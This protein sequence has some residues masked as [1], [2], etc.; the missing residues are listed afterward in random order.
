M[1]G[2]RLVVFDV[3]GTLIDSQNAIVA[4][5]Q[6]AFAA[7]GESAPSSQTILSIVGLSLPEAMDAIAPDLPAK[8]RAEL[9][10]SYKQSAI[11][12]S[13][14]SATSPLYPGAF[15]ALDE[16]AANPEVRL[17]IATGKARRGLDHSLDVHSLHHYFVTTQTADNHPSKPNPSMLRAA[18]S[19][20][21]CSADK[22]V[23][24]GDTE[25][26]IA[27]GLAAGFATVGVGWGYH[28]SA[29]LH[30]AGAHVVIDT[31][32]QLRAALQEIWNRA[33]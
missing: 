25:Y 24:I 21:G 11:G 9:V 17:G 26:D 18:L 10:Q 13:A 30:R 7:I 5:M 23:M 12:L 20:T 29:R 15:A 14:S 4:C 31:F 2:Q 1:R 8:T 22:A 6:T 32:E 3:D 27:M 33:T 19:E 16:L 28:P